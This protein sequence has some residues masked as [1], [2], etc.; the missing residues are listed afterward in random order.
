MEPKSSKVTVCKFSKQFLSGGIKAAVNA[1]TSFC[2]KTISTS[3]KQTNSWSQKHILKR[4][5]DAAE[6]QFTPTLEAMT[7][8]CSELFPVLF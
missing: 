6:E 7:Q 2:A 5:E 8:T 1:I 4:R 3:V